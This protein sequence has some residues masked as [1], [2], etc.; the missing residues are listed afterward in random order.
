MSRTRLLLPTA[1]A[2]AARPAAP[3]RLGA[4]VRGRVSARLAALLAAL[5]ASSLLA[6]APARGAPAGDAAPAAAA[7]SAEADGATESQLLYQQALQSISEG[8]KNDASEALSRVIEQEPLHAGAWL[9]L[10]LIQCALGHAD[11]AERLFAAIEVRFNPPDGIIELIAEA[12]AAGCHNWQ[13]HSQS[14]FSFSRG[15]DQNVNQGSAATSYLVNQG[16]VEVELPQPLDFQPK[17]DQFSLLS[18]DYLRDLTPN[19]SSGFVQLQARRYDRLRQFDS[20]SLFVGADTPWRFGRWTVRGSATLGLITLGNQLYQRQSQLQ[21][22]IGPP[23]PLPN[24]LQFHLTAGLTHVE[25]LTLNNFNANTAELR[26]QLSYRNEDD[27]ASASLGLLDD[28]ALAA[29]PGGDR[30][31]LQAGVQWRR[32]LVGELTGE[33]AYS[34]Q[35]WN[36]SS[37]YS[38]GF[39]DSVRDQRTDIWRATLSYPLSRTQTLQIEARQVR[40]KESISIFQYNDRQLQISW[41]W[42]SP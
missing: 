18:A 17:H 16:G 21:A 7:A 34:H 5:L 8:R 3:V 30:R 35:R 36:G 6:G 42:F 26:G 19:G 32:R 24:S 38:P 15:I 20:N 2:P 14:S 40:N 33:L 4:P 10:A 23:L 31:G 11:E 9:D 39:L 29:R 41:Q 1:D 28:R 37:A 12:R 22:R 25:Y 13:P 27:Y